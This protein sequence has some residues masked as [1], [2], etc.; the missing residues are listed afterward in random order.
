[1]PSL[2][3]GEKGLICQFKN[4]RLLKEHELIQDD[5]WVRNGVIL[6]PEK[7][8]FDEKAYADIQIDCNDAIISP[9]F[10]DV[11]INGKIYIQWYSKNDDLI[12]EF[13]KAL[14]SLIATAVQ[15]K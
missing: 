14:I 4:C 7:L 6:N 12:A 15:G 2:T 10:I 9:G 1:M 13:Y 8:F 5:L 3:N 11:Q